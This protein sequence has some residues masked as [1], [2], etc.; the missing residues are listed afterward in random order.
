MSDRYFGTHWVNDEVARV[1]QSMGNHGAYASATT[2]GGHH[3]CQMSKGEQ[4]S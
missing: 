1:V 3:P 2:W 4:R